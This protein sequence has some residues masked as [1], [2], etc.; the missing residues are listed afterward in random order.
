MFRSPRFAV[1][2]FLMCLAKHCVC[3]SPIF[4]TFAGM[5]VAYFLIAPRR[6]IQKTTAP[7]YESDDCSAQTE[8]CSHKWQS[9]GRQERRSLSVLTTSSMLNVK[10]FGRKREGVGVRVLAVFLDQSLV[11]L[12]R[13]AVLTLHLPGLPRA[14]WSAEASSS[15]CQGWCIHST[16]GRS[17]SRGHS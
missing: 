16:Q 3:R 5:S 9:F 4:L 10:R 1:P 8:K 13:L 17:S 12:S 14:L 11:L 6:D 15:S 7:L 2:W